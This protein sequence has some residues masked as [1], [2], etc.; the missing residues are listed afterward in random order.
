MPSQ[1]WHLEHHIDDDYRITD[2]ATDPWLGFIA[3]TGAEEVVD[4]TGWF[5]VLPFGLV[6]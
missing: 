2:D 4:M 6:R 5:K 1:F 3:D